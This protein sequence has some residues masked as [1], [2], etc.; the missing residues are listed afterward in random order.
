MQKRLGRL[1]SDKQAVKVA[2]KAGA[3]MNSG[4]KSQKGISVSSGA[5]AIADGKITIQPKS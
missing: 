1:L 5:I 2:K 3:Y 4:S